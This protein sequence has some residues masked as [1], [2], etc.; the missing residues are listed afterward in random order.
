[1]SDCI[2]NPKFFS[3]SEG[4][5]FTLNTKPIGIP[6][7]HVLY[8][9]P[10]GEELNR[11][12]T[13]IAS[14]AKIFAAA[15]LECTV[16]DYY[17]TGDSDGDFCQGDLSIWQQDIAA[18]VS[19]IHKEQD[20]SIYLAGFRLGALFALSF[21]NDNPNLVESCLLIQPVINGKQFVTQLLRQR[22]AGQINN[23][24]GADSTEQ[25]RAA[26]ADG[27]NIEVGG[28]EFNS[29]LLLALDKLS[30][31]NFTSLNKVKCHWLE[32]QQIADKGLSIASKRTVDSLINNGNTV[33]TQIASDPPIWQ[34][35]ER[36]F[37]FNNMEN[38]KM[39]VE[40]W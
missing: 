19:S 37:A 31:S 23:G 1:M 38:V 3:G 21:I 5:L 11:C 14:H 8:L 28:Y 6:R 22:L 24:L 30:I 15:G 17:G 18:L 40:Q 9:P 10:V 34:L 7:G 35:N 20:G 4:N 36:A 12:R 26:M 25:M 29:D 39:V 13:V 2:L 27:H 33:E 32:F 16:V